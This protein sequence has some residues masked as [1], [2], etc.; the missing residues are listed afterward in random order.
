MIYCTGK[1]EEFYYYHFDGPGSV[2]ALWKAAGSKA[3]G[4][5]LKKT[6]DVY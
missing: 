1:S 3:K 4:T 2:A 6:K 5:R